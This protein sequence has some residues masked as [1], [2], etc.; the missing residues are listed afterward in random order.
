M[1]NKHYLCLSISPSSSP[2]LRLSLAVSIPISISVSLPVPPSPRAP[3]PALLRLC[4]PPSLSPLHGRLPQRVLRAAVVPHVE[5]GVARQ[6]SE[7]HSRQRLRLPPPSVVPAPAPVPT[8]LPLLLLTPLPQPRTV[9]IRVHRQVSAELLRGRRAEVAAA[10]RVRRVDRAV[11]RRVPAQARRAHACVRAARAPVQHAVA[12]A[13]HRAA[14]AAARRV[15]GQRHR[16]VAAAAAGLTLFRRDRNTRH[17]G[18]DD[19]LLH[20]RHGD[21]VLPVH[22]VR[23]VRLRRRR[24][25]AA[26]DTARRGDGRP[27]RRPHPSLRSLVHL[28]ML[29]E[30]SEV[31]DPIWTEVAAVA[32]RRARPVELLVID[33]VVAVAARVRTLLARVP[34]PAGPRLRRRRPRLQG[35]WRG[36]WRGGGGDVVDVRHDD[37]LRGEVQPRVLVQ[38]AHRAHVVR[39]VLAL[40]VAARLR[41]ETRNGNVAPP[42]TQPSTDLRDGNVT[43]PATRPSTDL[44]KISIRRL[45]TN[46]SE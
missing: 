8:P 23:H 4:V 15:P 20:Q 30:Q 39:T 28:A 31:H 12:P 27:R 7:P 40:E 35:G 42:A 10:A 38:Q 37:A 26:G 3:V 18:R 9:L 45:L 19:A 14:V 25:Q 5:V 16:R 46:P 29:R 22:V 11:A 32:R 41:P 13:G 34:R 44:R 33:V 24:Q 6:I 1:L 2:G 21:R 43:P 17:F 36:G